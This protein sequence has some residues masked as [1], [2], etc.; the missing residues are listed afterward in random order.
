MVSQIQD[1]TQVSVDIATGEG[2]AILS[3][4]CSLHT[5]ILRPCLAVR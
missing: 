1:V 5:S 2:Q 3:E 4:K